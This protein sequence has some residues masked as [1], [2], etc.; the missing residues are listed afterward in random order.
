MAPQQYEAV[1]IGGYTYRFVKT[2]TSFFY[3]WQESV[4]DSR[5]VKIATAEKALIDLVMFHRTVY[6]VDLS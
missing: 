3:G 4:L 6:A 1:A 2:N 5:H